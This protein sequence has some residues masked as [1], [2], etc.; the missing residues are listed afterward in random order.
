MTVYL[1]FRKF[2]KEWPKLKPYSSARA[3]AMNRQSGLAI[4]H[5][6]TRGIPLWMWLSPKMKVIKTTGDK[7]LARAKPVNPK[8]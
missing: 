3:A 7:I 6:V 1:N 5:R 2:Q 4:A 8:P